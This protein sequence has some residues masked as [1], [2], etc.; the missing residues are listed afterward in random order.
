MGKMV[1]PAKLIKAEQEAFF[2]KE[3]GQEMSMDWK[4]Q[5]RRHVINWRVML[6]D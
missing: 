3:L 5:W 1:V 4:R 2:T 6:I